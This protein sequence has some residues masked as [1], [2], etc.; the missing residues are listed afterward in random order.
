MR[1]P[2]IEPVSFAF[3]WFGARASRFALILCLTAKCYRQFPRT[4]RA[5]VDGLSTDLGPQ[6]YRNPTMASF[7][8]VDTTRK[9]RNL[10]D[11]FDSMLEPIAIDIERKLTSQSP[12][13]TVQISL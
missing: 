7:E 12:S 13:I 9:L 1:Q 5:M 11:G 3:V 4:G 8:V 10:R 6:T 2:R